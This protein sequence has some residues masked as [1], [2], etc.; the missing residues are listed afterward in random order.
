[1]SK[2]K[3]KAPDSDEAVLELLRPKEKCKRL[4]AGDYSDYDDDHSTADLVICGAIAQG[5]RRRPAPPC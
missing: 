5:C 1:M 3:P 4:L 2:A